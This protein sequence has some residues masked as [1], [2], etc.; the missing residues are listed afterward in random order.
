MK[1]KITKTQ[2]SNFKNNYTCKINWFKNQW[3]EHLSLQI[4][5]VMTKQ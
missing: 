4:K 3:L 5:Y 1:N 2:F